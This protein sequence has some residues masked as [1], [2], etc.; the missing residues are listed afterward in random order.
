MVLYILF[1]TPLDKYPQT[2]KS[3]LN[4]PAIETVYTSLKTVPKKI[5][6]SKCENKI[7]PSPIRRSL[8]R[9]LYG[10]ITVP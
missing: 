1:L 9:L 2:K 4:F 7:H 6:P 8:T 3:H 10:Y 5:L